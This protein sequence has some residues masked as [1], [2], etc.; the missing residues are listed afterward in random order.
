MLIRKAAATD[1]VQ[2]AALEEQAG[3]SHWSYAQIH[4][5]IK[6]MPAWLMFDEV[7][8]DKTIGYVFFSH[9]LDECE[10]LNIVTHPDYRR[11]GLGKKLLLYGFEQLQR[12][13]I[14]SCFLEVAHSNE[15]AIALYQKLAFNTVGERK[16]YYGQDKHAWLMAKQ[17]KAA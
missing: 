13:G 7:Q 15:Q 2:I 5:A 16:H 4:D 8:S 14:K 12:L 10:L 3:F 6:T 9:V 17:L 11:Q 1:V